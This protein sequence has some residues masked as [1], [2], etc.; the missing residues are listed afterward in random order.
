MLVETGYWPG[1]IPFEADELAT[2]VA[3]LNERAKA[4][5]KANRGR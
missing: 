3:V 4:A 2:V 5:R 1:S